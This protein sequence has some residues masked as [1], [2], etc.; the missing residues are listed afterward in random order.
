MRRLAE[1]DGWRCHYCH[2]R[3]IPLGE[4]EDYCAARFEPYGK[5]GELIKVYTIPEGYSSPTLDHKIS[6]HQGG[7]DEIE[8]L[9][10]ACVPCNSRKQHRH[11]YEEFYELT[12]KFR[13]EG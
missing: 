13:G 8:N 2:T 3:L 1:T 4:E 12:A 11:T 7:G 6:Q 10:L 9:V 5:S